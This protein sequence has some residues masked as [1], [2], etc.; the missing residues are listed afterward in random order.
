MDADPQISDT[1]VL[2]Y[3]AGLPTLQAA[4]AAAVLEHEPQRTHLL[5][6]IPEAAL[7]TAMGAGGARRL[8]SRN[9][10]L[11]ARIRRLSDKDRRR[12][13]SVRDAVAS[14]A[15]LQAEAQAVLE[16][17]RIGA[18]EIL[19]R[20]KFENVN[21]VLRTGRPPPLVPNRSK[22]RMSQRMRNCRPGPTKACMAMKSP[23][24]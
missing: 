5:G 21:L 13:L 12:V 2:E 10:Q 24:A 9:R 18:P 11:V 15:A 23:S 16:Y 3:A 14:G 7:L 8:I 20:L 22:R 17:G 19:A 6:L 4:G 1:A